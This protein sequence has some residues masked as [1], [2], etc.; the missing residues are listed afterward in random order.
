MSTRGGG[1]SQ[2]YT[3]RVR[4]YFGTIPADRYPMITSMAGALT[5]NVGDERF[6]FG[7]DIL[8]AGLAR[9]VG[10]GGPAAA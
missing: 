6:D 1:N 10:A 2:E 7:L 9:Q 8:V 5:R 3:D 4:D